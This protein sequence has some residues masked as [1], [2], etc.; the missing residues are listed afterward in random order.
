MSSWVALLRVRRGYRFLGR[1]LFT[2]PTLSSTTTRSYGFRPAAGRAVPIREFI[3]EVGSLANR[4]VRT[5]LPTTSVIPEWIKLPIAPR[6][7]GCTLWMS[8]R[9]I[10]TADRQSF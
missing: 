8:G 2:F 10:R 3:T 6:F 4:Q 1:D 5:G 9:I 7:L